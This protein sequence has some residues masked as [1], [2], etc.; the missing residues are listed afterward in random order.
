[1]AGT[2]KGPTPL[3][4]EFGDRVRRLRHDL[5]LSQEDLAH[6]AG[7]NRTYIGS[8]E[9]GQRNISLNNIVKLAGALGVDTGE[10]VKGLQ[11]L[12]GRG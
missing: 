3:Q 12:R 2:G 4:R 10:L 8:L 11:G 9:A 6:R 1:M 5:G 7:I